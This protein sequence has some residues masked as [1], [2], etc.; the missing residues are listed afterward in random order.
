MEF[1]EVQTPHSPGPTPVSVVGSHL[2]EGVLP[3]GTFL[4]P[5]GSGPLGPGPS[6]VAT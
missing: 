6:I 3:A 5:G 1:A 2:L 4:P